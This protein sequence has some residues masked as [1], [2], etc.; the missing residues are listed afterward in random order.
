MVLPRLSTTSQA[1]TWQLTSA[2]IQNWVG[3]AASADATK[4]VAA[5]FNVL[6]TGGTLATSTNAGLTWIGHQTNLYWQT[7]ASSADGKKHIAAIYGGDVYIS[8][9][10]GATWTP[11]GAHQPLVFSGLLGRRH[12]SGSCRGR[13]LRNGQDLCVSTARAAGAGIG[14]FLDFNQYP[15]RLV[16][17][18][19]DG[20]DSGGE[21]QPYRQQLEPAVGTGHGRRHEQVHHRQSRSAFHPLPALQTLIPNSAHETSRAFLRLRHEI[22]ARAPAPRNV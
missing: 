9:N 22:R 5:A 6:G 10:A 15:S 18:G 13:Q 4:L 2:P 17:L 3:V 21:D 1:Q 20:V 16:A 7:V 14:H 8:T 11:L 12:A 19:L